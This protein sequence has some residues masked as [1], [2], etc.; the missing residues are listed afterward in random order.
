[1][2]YTD[3]NSCV[4]NCDN[5]ICELAYNSLLYKSEYACKITAASYS[6]FWWFMII[7]V[8]TFVLFCLLCCCCKD[9][10]EHQTKPVQKTKKV[11]QPSNEMQKTKVN[12]N[13]TGIAPQGQLVTLQ[14]GQVG[15]FIPLNQSQDQVPFYLPIYQ[16]PIYG[17]QIFKEQETVNNYEAMY[18]PVM[19]M[20]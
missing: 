3:F 12:Q 20:Q 1:M 17:Q 10:D 6:L 11:I 19:L 13:V 16:Q 7:P 18:M 14:N 9:K 8:I 4:R 15:I 2:T 5:G